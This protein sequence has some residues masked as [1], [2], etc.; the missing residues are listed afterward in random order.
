MGIYDVTVTLREGMPVYPGDADFRL[1]VLSAIADGGSCNLSALHVGAHCG[2]HIDAPNHMVDGRQTVDGIEPSILVGPATVVAIENP[3]KITLDELEQ[4]EWDGV[5]RALFKTAN[6]GK[7]GQLDEFIE[8]YVYMEASAAEFLAGQGLVL[9]GVDYLS[10]DPVDWAGDRAHMPLLEAGII[11]V[12]GLDLSEVPPG[13]YEMFCGA[14]KV[15]D[16]DGAP[17]RVLLR[18]LER[19][20]REQG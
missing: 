1:E 9:V 8:D 6:S 3:Q 5:E 19:P 12:E 17:A 15:R 18:T 20:D 16:G 7:L 13:Q 14:L 11:L 4:Y 10:V 2:T